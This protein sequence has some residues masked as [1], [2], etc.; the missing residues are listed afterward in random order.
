MNISNLKLVK[1]SKKYKEVEANKDITIE[2][3]KGEIIGIVGPNGSG[4]T[5]MM[6]IISGLI[7]N[8]DGQYLIDNNDAKKFSNKQFVKNFG[9]YIEKPNLLNNFSGKDNLKFFRNYFYG[10]IDR[11]DFNKDYNE[12]V[13]SLELEKF[14]DKKVKKYSLGMKQRLAI[15]SAIMSRPDFCILDEPTNGMD[16]ES[17]YKVLE[18]LKLRKKDTGFLISSHILDTIED[19][20]DKIYALKDGKIISYFD[21]KNFKSKY[22]GMMI[23]NFKENSHVD[24][25]SIHDIKYK[26]SDSIIVLENN[27]KTYDT[28][29]ELKSKNI[30]FIIE[31]RSATR[32]F[33]DITMEV[34]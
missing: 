33:Y 11:I 10:S 8:Y 24:N 30:D 16:I 4:K 21:L 23:L 2:I 29:K 26:L 5:T 31:D 1:V 13:N 27:S 19:V 9:I 17:S 34:N 20:C 18:Y 25:I 3:N 7:K 22:D 15:A 12:V 6:K 28:L 32:I 14:I